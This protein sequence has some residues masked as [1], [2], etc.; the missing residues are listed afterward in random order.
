MERHIII[1][2]KFKEKEIIENIG[3]KIDDFEIFKL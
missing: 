2:Q 3:N 1:E